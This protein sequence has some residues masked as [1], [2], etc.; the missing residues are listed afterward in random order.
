MVQTFLHPSEQPNLKRCFRKVRLGRI[1]AGL[2]SQTLQIPAGWVRRSCPRSCSS[3]PTRR[4]WS[5]IP[6]PKRTVYIRTVP[7]QTLLWKSAIG[8][9]RKRVLIT[10]CQDIQSRSTWL[11]VGTILCGRFFCD[12]TAK[13]DRVGLH[14]VFDQQIGGTGK[15]RVLITPGTTPHLDFPIR[16]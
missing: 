13:A 5:G 1:V 12:H 4:M 3:T 7:E 14:A 16:L 6:A 11:L 9:A 8:H 2:K 15:V 10:A